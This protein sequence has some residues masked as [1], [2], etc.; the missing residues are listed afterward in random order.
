MSITDR[1]IHSAPVLYTEKGFDATVFLSRDRNID[2]KFKN[3]SS[4]RIYITAHVIKGVAKIALSVEFVY[5]ANRS[6]MV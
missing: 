2:F 4:S 6:E 1:D 3:T 5:T